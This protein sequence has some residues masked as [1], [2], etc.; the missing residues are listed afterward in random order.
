MRQRYLLLVHCEHHL[1]IERLAELKK[2]ITF[3]DTDYPNDS[4]AKILVSNDKCYNMGDLLIHDVGNDLKIEA[5]SKIEKE[6]NLPN[7]IN[8]IVNK[9]YRNTIVVA[10]SHFPIEEVLY[11]MN[12]ELSEGSLLALSELE[13]GKVLFAS[14]PHV[15]A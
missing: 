12:I 10:V 9:S 13:H 7:F 5:V 6:R 2:A 4:G 1:P 15:W 14:E 3:I 8:E 11:S